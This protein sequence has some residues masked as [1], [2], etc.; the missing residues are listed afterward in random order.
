MK[1]KQDRCE[2]CH[3]KKEKVHWRGK[4]DH[5]PTGTE[6]TWKQNWVRGGFGLAKSTAS[7]PMMGSCI[8][9]QDKLDIKSGGDR[10]V[11]GEEC[12]GST[13]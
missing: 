11:P 1:R 9:I 4:K 10:R 5:E 2:M 6:G 8:S 13:V 7:W 3:R 12:L